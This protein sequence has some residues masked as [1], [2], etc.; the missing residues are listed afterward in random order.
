MLRGCNMDEKM[1]RQFVFNGLLLQDSFETL[2]KEGISVSASGDFQQVS[3]VVE[4][5]FSPRIWHNA[6]DMASVYQAVFCIE[7]TLR[8]FIVERMSERHGLDWWEE[9]VSSK[10]KKAV[11]ALKEKEEKNKF[12]SS[13]SDSEIGYTMLGN[14]GQIII[15]NWDDFSDIIPSQAW[16]SS[17]MD[18]LEMA[19]NIVMHTGVLPQIEIDRIASIVRDILRQIG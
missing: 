18:D 13:R 11:N 10:I 5:D 16:L 19:R 3:R 12:F 17:R 4:A 8:N 6:T 7:N 9:R 2:Q 1:L 14:L 15:D